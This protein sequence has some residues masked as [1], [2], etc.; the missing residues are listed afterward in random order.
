MV[1]RFACWKSSLSGYHFNVM[2]LAC[3]T[4]NFETYG[5]VVIVKLT[6]HSLC[7]FASTV[8]LRKSIFKFSTS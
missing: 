7:L 4:R 3:T 1:G 5:S 6:G 8:Y 2:R